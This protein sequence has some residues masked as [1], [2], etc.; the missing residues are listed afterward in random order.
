MCF[1]EGSMSDLFLFNM[2]LNLNKV[3]KIIFLVFVN[4]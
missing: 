4:S 2:L 1:N 3:N